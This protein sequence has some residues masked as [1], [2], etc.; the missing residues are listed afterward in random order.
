M[1]LCR[2]SGEFD[3]ELSR[4]RHVENGQADRNALSL[5]NDFVE[6]TATCGLIGR[7]RTDDAVLIGDDLSEQF[8]RL[9]LRRRTDDER[10]DFVGSSRNPVVDQVEIEVR[11]SVPREFQCRHSQVDVAASLQQLQK[12]RVSRKIEVRAHGEGFEA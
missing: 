10:A 2:D 1:H 4:D 8:E 7:R 9:S 12:L 5:F 3:T 6:K 11:V